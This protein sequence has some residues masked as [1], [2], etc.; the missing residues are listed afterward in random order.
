M[1]RILD[2]TRCGC[3]IAPGDAHLVDGGASA[4]ASDS[5]AWLRMRA[6]YTVVTYEA[7]SRNCVHARSRLGAFGA[8]VELRCVALS[9]RAETQTFYDRPA[10][11]NAWGSLSMEE[12]ESNAVEVQTTRLDDDK[13]HIFLLKLDLQGGESAA[14]RGA[15]GLIDVGNISWIFCELDDRLLRGSG[16]SARQLVDALADAGFACVNSRE[17]SW[18]RM[19]HYTLP[20]TSNATFWTNMLCA[21]STVASWQGKTI[22]KTQLAASLMPIMK[23]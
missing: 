18:R 8:R 3:V 11:G 2:K 15:S 21:H 12:S 4:D 9:D 16:S 7:L 23:V 1:S 13:R 19:N 20:N 5:V 14:L 10:M 22:W 17:R 6:Q